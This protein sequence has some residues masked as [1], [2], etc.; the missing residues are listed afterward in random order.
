[1]EPPSDDEPMPPVVREILVSLD[2][3]FR[4]RQQNKF[5]FMQDRFNSLLK[6]FRDI[7]EP[8]PS[9]H[10]YRVAKT[11]LIQYARRNNLTTSRLVEAPEPDVAGMRGDNR[12]NY[13]LLCRAL[14]REANLEVG[15]AG[16][17]QRLQKSIESDI[18]KLGL[19]HKVTDSTIGKLLRI[20]PELNSVTKFH[21]D[22]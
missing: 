1:M 19:S 18:K 15:Q 14:M 13:W 3:D 11:W 6:D 7:P 4:E 10:D 5:S 8:P 20:Q 12:L 21:K 9:G 17:Y 2:T 16:L 22:S